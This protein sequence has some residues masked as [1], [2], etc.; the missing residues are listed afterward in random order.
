VLLSS[1]C[2]PD[3]DTGPPNLVLISLDDLSAHHIGAYGYE[4]PTTPFLDQ[5]ARRGTLFE[6]AVAQ[7]TWTLPSHASMLSSR[8]VGGHGVWNIERRFPEG[9]ALI[10]EVL[11]DAGWDTAA[12]TACLFVS[13]RY[14]LDRGFDVMQTELKPAQEIT[15]LALEHLDSLGDRPFFLFLH[16]YDVHQPFDEPNPYGQDFAEG[17]SVEELEDGWRMAGLIGREARDLDEEDIAWLEQLFPKSRIR[18][19]IKQAVEHGSV[20]GDRI[21]NFVYR[22]L[23]GRGAEALEARKARYD[24]GIANMD[25]RLSELFERLAKYPWFDNTVFMITSD[26]G[27]SFNEP[28]GVIGHGGPGYSEQAR[29]PL[30]VVGK[31]I[32]PGHRVAQA[33]ASVDIAPTLLELAGVPAP[34]DFQGQGFGAALRGGGVEQRPILTGAL[35][36]GNAA[37]RAD[38]WLLLVTRNGDELKLLRDE[39]GSSQDE[40]PGRSDIVDRL[41]TWLEAM[42]RLNR[43]LASDLQASEVQLDEEERERL[44]ELGYL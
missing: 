40:S 29:V 12:F 22:Y 8:F 10:Q 11:R 21:M 31:D 34:D 4:R 16:Y 30:I 24:N 1:A 42:E 37:V 14:G 9:P 25:K 28:P 19:H 26:H 23:A 32:Q 3:G 44:H 35:D 17:L 2:A 43:Q 13:E 7:A 33:T 15:A 41:N 38:Q 36:A 18:H 5:L 39:P 20:L 6:N 27:E